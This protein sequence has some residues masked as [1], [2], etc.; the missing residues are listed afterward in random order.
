MNPAQRGAKRSP[1]PHAGRFVGCLPVVRQVELV[2]RQVRA[3]SA[4]RDLKIQITLYFR[5]ESAPTARLCPSC[6]VSKKL[7]TAKLCA[8]PPSR[9]DGGK[10]RGSDRGGP[11]AWTQEEVRSQHP[12][13]QNLFSRLSAIRNSVRRFRKTLRLFVE[14]L[15]FAALSFDR[16]PQRL[17][18]L[19]GRSEF[20][21]RRF[22]G[23]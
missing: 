2:A 12:N 5:E 22:G 6:I 11:M 21:V 19:G 3:Y 20:G 1:S 18:F 23:R 17:Q 7:S 10:A 4:T 14:R 16:G 15:H 9:L 13:K 8:T